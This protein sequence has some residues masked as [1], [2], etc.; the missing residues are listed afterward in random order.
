M[1]GYLPV[2]IK[3]PFQSVTATADAELQMEFGFGPCTSSSGVV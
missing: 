2:P 3:P 1:Q